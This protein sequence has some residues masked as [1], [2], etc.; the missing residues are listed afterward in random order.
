MIEVSN[1]GSEVQP[2]PRCKSSQV[3]ANERQAAGSSCHQVAEPLSRGASVKE[4][5]LVLCDQFNMFLYEF[6]GHTSLDA[7]CAVA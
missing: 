7:E 4:L 6:P 2:D 1:S 3:K 5:L